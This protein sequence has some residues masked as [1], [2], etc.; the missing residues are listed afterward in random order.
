MHHCYPERVLETPADV[1]RAAMDL[2]ARREHSRLE[3]ARKLSARVES[4]ETLKQVLDR[5]IED[6]LLS[7]ERFCEAFI[8]SR[9][10]R[11][12]GP[13]RISME[14]RKRGVEDV[15]VHR[16]LDPHASLWLESLIDL[17]TRKYGP[18]PDTSPVALAKQQRFLQHRGF[19]FEQIR[20]AFDRL[21]EMQSVVC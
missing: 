5:L 15:L 3:I 20:V 7:N 2:L 4:A 21:A 1:R 19:T 16:Y 10:N 18:V 12:Q 9:V 17:I 11:G 8:R 6:T 13:R 14:L